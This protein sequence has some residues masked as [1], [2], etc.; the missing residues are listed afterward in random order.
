[1]ECRRLG[2]G[3]LVFGS[4]VFGPLVVRPLVFGRVVLRLVVAVHGTLTKL[5]A[6]TRT[7]ALS[8]ALGLIAALAAVYS[9]LSA[10]QLIS[11]PVA[12][13]AIAVTFFVAEQNLVNVEFRRQSHSLT[14]AGVPLALGILLL[15][16]H[17]LVLAR[18]I[19]SIAALLWQ[20]IAAEKV[21]YNTAAFCFEAAVS[22]TLLH[23]L[24]PRTGELNLQ[25]VAA[26]MVCIAAV[27]QLM[28]LLVL[29]VIWM[30]VGPITRQD[31][32]EVL[33][34]AVILSVVATVFASA[35]Y[36]L[37]QQGI[38][39]DLLALALVTMA[40]FIYRLYASTSRRHQS[41]AVVHDFVTEG[42]GAETVEQLA[43]R[44][45][46][47]MRHVLRASAVELRLLDNNVEGRQARQDT[48]LQ[49]SL[50]EDD[51]LFHAAARSS[52]STDWVHS[53]AMHHGE[54][55]LATHGHDTA[56]VRWLDSLN[57]KDAIVVP[58]QSGAT[59]LGT[60]TV[61]DRL[62]DTATFTNDDLKMLQTLTSHFAVAV[63]SARLMEE[64]SFEATHDAL[65]GLANRAF[66]SHQIDALGAAPS[67]SAVLLLDLDKFKE[68]ND[69][70]GHDVGDQLLIVIA[71]R[72][73]TCLP[74]NATVARLGG[75]EFAV[76]LPGGAD[77]PLGAAAWAQLA[78]DRILAPVRFAEA[79]LTP[80]VSIGIAMSP[81]VAAEN[82]L[83]CADTAM[84]VAKSRRESVVVYETSM[85]SGR[86]ERLALVADLRV[87]LENAPRQFVLHYQPKIDLATGAVVSTE[88]LVRWHHPALGTLSPDTFIPLAEA[89]GLID[90]LTMHL[91]TAALTECAAWH[92]RG[93]PVTVAVNLS[94]R[95]LA[96]ANVIEH[97]AQ[98]ITAS[99]VQAE[100]LILE[101]TESAV[102]DD[103][104]VSVAALTRFA[105]LG[106]CLSLD[107][108]GTGYSSLSYLQRLPVK[109][110]KIDMTFVSALTEDSADGSAE[111]LFRSITAMGANLNKRIVAEGIETKAQLDAV[112]ALGCQIGQGYLISRPLSAPAFHRWLDDHQTP[113]RDGLHLVPDSA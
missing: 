15:P 59:I 113:G 27:D 67:S 51:Q 12:A 39:G 61:T 42:V 3:P 2:L 66:L 11:R 103:P 53:K 95:N 106:I 8:F 46:A 13:V 38:V 87:A 17:E 74:D 48:Y 88:A 104:E 24:L 32:V 70:L 78:S 18:L 85:D 5:S 102:M 112:T 41:L 80:E 65:T 81:T 55:T 1:M 19:G 36:I 58:L 92:R 16:V 79:L 86:A 35:M 10:D 91:V 29:W 33:V 9:A 96:N 84:Y 89:T 4:L 54:P 100:S 73:R 108:F 14:F 45:L 71:E 62:G 57:L 23:A 76:L 75:D 101:I 63:S 34:P 50:G 105:E 69:V 64:L 26:L 47:R 21:I 90:Q 60:V 44:S 99:G 107:D 68:V 98:A 111:A 82:L 37:I 20:R 40:V 31:L 25:A 77:D 83:Q 52:H 93:H 7:L 22:G 6:R 94:A 30:H 109:E 43:P 72:L 97:I 28:S 110:L 49:L 56:V